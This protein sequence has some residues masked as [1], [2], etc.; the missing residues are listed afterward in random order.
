MF[1]GLW[2]PVL[3]AYGSFHKYRQLK[4]QK[5]LIKLKRSLGE[6]VD[7]EPVYSDMEDDPD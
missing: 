3:L 4:K 5:E 6:P 7:E 2:A 1:W